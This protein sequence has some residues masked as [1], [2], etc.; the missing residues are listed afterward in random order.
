[1]NQEDFEKKYEQLII[2]SS[3][4]DIINLFNQKKNKFKFV[5]QKIK[6]KINKTEF[7]HFVALG[8]DNFSQNSLLYNFFNLALKNERADVIEYMFINKYI[9]ELSLTKIIKSEKILKHILDNE[10]IKNSISP[11]MC[12]AM[13]EYC[14]MYNIPSS[15]DIICKKCLET[16]KKIEKNYQVDILLACPKYSSYEMLDKLLHMKEPFQFDIEDKESLYR[17]DN[18][19]ILSA[20]FFNKKI[21]KYLLTSPELE[22]HAD[23][24]ESFFEVEKLRHAKE[25]FD[26][27]IFELKIPLTTKLENLLEQNNHKEYLEMFKKR[28]LM[29][30]IENKLPIKNDKTKTRKI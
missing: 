12:C 14:S 10:K 15:F 25:I 22:K 3:L 29:L 11:E 1:M 2:S 8:Y 5:I 9:N 26:Y 4:K 23:L 21:L 18:L 16:V 19:L 20:K 24:S 30:K 7:A 27:I 28:D 6:D 13:L 17:R